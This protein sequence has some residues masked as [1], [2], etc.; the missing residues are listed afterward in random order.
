MRV[1]R[2]LTSVLFVDKTITEDSVSLTNVQLYE[3]VLVD[4]VLEVAHEHAL[5]DLAEITQV[6]SVMRL[7]W[8]W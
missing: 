8:R 4:D 1:S 3:V 7:S 2:E 5:D 6:E